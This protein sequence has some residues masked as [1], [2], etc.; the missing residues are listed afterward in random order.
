MNR[1]V[2]DDVTCKHFFREPTVSLDKQINQ[3]VRKSI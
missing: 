1:L 3:I 2:F